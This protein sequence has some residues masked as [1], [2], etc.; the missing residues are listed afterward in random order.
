MIGSQQNP[1]DTDTH[2][3]L[4][5]D[6]LTQTHRHMPT[7][8]YTP[9]HTHAVT[10]TRAPIHT[11]RHTPT[12]TH[13]VTDTQPHTQTHRFP[14]THTPTLHTHAVKLTLPRNSHCH[15]TQTDR[16]PLGAEH[17]TLNTEH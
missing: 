3:Q 11:N 7:R 8:L 4:H 9:T 10:Q 5:A 14:H 13:V 15:A 17:R 1:Y 12:H 16:G 6:A 2:T